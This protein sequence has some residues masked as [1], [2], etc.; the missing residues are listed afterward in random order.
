MKK[1]STL[2][3]IIIIVAVAVIAV[4]GVFAYKYYYSTQKQKESVSFSNNCD[5][6]RTQVNTLV[7]EANYCNTDSDCSI[8]TEVVKFC[9]CWSLINKNADLSKIKEGSEKYDTLNCPRLL[10]AQ[11][12]IAPQEQNIKC[13]NNKCI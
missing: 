6:L 3:G 8:S 13:E 11:C 12:P 2:T 7:E 5:A 1:I 10:C 4:G 9:G